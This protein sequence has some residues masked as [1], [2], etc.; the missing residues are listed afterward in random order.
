M[1]SVCLL[2]VGHNFGDA[3][4]L[5]AADFAKG[6]SGLTDSY[7]DW[8]IGLSKSWMGA[9]YGITYSDLTDL[10]GVSGSGTLLD[11]YVKAKCKDDFC[12]SKIVASIGKSF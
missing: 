11:P 9:D 2:H 12:G 4:D 5:G 1:R 3:F 7:T 8:S 6:D 10:E